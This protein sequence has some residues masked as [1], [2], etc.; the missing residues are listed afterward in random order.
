[1]QHDVD[2]QS[3]FKIN[4]YLYT[5]HKGLSYYRQVTQYTEML[6]PAKIG[7]RLYA[8]FNPSPTKT[9]YVSMIDPCISARRNF[10]RGGSEVHQGKACKGVTAWGV[11]GV[12]AP[13]TPEKF[14]KN[15]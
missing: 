5:K 3:V 11:P 12:G 7:S 2:N 1:M 13:R 8:Y 9:G 4:F 10:S 14:S 15:L 6:I